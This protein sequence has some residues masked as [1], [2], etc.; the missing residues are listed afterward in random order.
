MQRL[1]RGIAL[2]EESPPVELAIFPELWTVGF[3]SFERYAA[4]AEPLEGPTLAALSEV[5]R[6]RSM[7]LHGGSI[8]ERSKTGQLFNTSVLFNTEGRLAASYRKIHLFGFESSEQRILQP[9]SFLTVSTTSFGT[10][11]L[12]TCYD[13]RFP[14]LYRA[15]VDQAADTF[16]VA[17]AWPASRASHWTIFTRARAVENLSYLIACNACGTDHGTRLLGYSVVVD[18]WGEIVAQAGDAEQVL[19]AELDLERP[20]AIRSTFPALRDRR[21]ALRI[22]PE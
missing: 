5:A 17:S 9:G 4:A 15:L 22:Q 14:E 16:L 20:T 13:L 7:W 18:P 19:T 12:T 1:E 11:A 10:A 6:R 8:V 2:L 21:P 3:F